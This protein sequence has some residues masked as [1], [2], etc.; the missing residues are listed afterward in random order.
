M[1]I[2]FL[3]GRADMAATTRVVTTVAEVMAVSSMVCTEAL[4]EAGDV[5][6]SYKSS[7]TSTSCW[8]STCKCSSIP[9]GPAAA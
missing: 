8:L 4:V 7:N 6:R 5:I 2:I 9:A 1:I 3:I